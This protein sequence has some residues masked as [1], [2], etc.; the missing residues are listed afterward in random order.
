MRCA[1]TRRT[2]ITR[3]SSTS[4]PCGADSTASR[5]SRLMRPP[6]PLPG[7]AFR[8]TPASRARRRVAGE[9]MTRAGFAGALLRAGRGVRAGIGASVWIVTGVRV[10]T[11]ASTGTS[12]GGCDCDSFEPAV[13]KEINSA[14]TGIE[15]PGTPASARTRPVTGA[16]I[17]TT[18]LSVETSAIVWPSTT[19]SP[20]LTCQA[21][22]SA[23]TV[24]SPRSGILKLWT[25]MCPP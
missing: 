11:E 17:S 22:I 25:L 2:P 10:G 15:L 8:S 18:A 12:A 24:P 1:I 14:P 23:A 5:S 3:I 13:S 20:G 7:T 21:T 4:A 16:G 6:G 9:V 19:S